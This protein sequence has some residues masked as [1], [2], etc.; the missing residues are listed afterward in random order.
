MPE[1]LEIGVKVVAVLAAFL[2]VPLLV[3]QLEHKAM[4]HMQGRLGPMY[5]GG[6]HGWAQ[7]VADGVKFVQKED[8]VPAAADRTV[9]RLAPA[10]ALLPYLLVL[11]VV[12]LGPGTVAEKLDIGLFYALAITG[13]G[14]VGM[15]MGAWASANKYSLLGGLRGAAQLLAYELPLV[16]AA[17]SAA[18]AAG[19]LSLVGIAEAWRPWWLVWQAPAAVV[20]FVA[21]LAE[22]RRPPFDMP[23]ADS[24]LVFGYLTEYTGLRFAFFLLAEY[25]GIVVVC[26]LTAV[27]FLGGWQGPFLP[28][29]VWTLG[30][31][32]ALSFVVI[33]LRVACPRLR[34]DQLQ[35]LAWLVLVPI[36]L[37]QLVLT[38]VVKIVVT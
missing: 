15:L 27:L 9:F 13:I 1:A 8:V 21:G 17:A 19:T 22:I 34:E 2:V 30:K 7:L 23:L 3:G 32:F 16:L 38:G 24:E 18:M 33:W 37:A 28:G 5:A 11:V 6:F 4:A 12:P 20:F 36:A 35:R 26:A 31:V 14:V 25:A 29:P 10:V